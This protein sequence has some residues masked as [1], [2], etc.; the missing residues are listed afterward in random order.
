[1]DAFLSSWLF[2]LQRKMRARGGVVITLRTHTLTI[3]E[4]TDVRAGFVI[5]RASECNNFL[6][7]RQYLC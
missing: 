5:V 3:I 6:V 4:L 7:Y 1:M 2:P